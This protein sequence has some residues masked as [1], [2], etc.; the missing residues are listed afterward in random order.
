MAFASWLE[1]YVYSGKLDD[2]SQSGTI[3]RGSGLPRAP[4]NEVAPSAHQRLRSAIVHHLLVVAS[5]RSGV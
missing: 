1:G 5:T 4:I 3:I 2:H